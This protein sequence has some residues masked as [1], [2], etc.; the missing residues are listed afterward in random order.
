MARRRTTHFIQTDRNDS[1]YVTPYTDG[2]FLVAVVSGDSGDF[3]RSVEMVLSARDIEVL[4]Q[5]FH[6]ETPEAE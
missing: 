4:R 2:S 5:A 6:D 1:V 3:G